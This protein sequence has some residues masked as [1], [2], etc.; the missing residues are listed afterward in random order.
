MSNINNKKMTC[1]LKEPPIDKV[2]VEGG[3]WITISELCRS[4]D[5]GCKRFWAARGLVPPSNRRY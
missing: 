5:E 4:I 1:G 3:K 2:Q